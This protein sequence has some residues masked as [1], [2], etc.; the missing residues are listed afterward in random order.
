M[1]AEVSDPGAMSLR[2]VTRRDDCDVWLETI[3]NERLDLP[4]T[5]DDNT[6]A[7]IPTLRAGVPADAHVFDSL[8][9]NITHRNGKP[10]SR[11]VVDG[12]RRSNKGQP[13][14]PPASSPAYLAMSVFLVPAIAAQFGWAIS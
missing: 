7:F 9:T 11:W 5:F 8:I 3:S 4:K 6:P 2:I 14:D 13:R 12:S 10:K 1:P